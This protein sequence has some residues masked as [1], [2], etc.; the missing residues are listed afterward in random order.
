MSAAPELVAGPSTAARRRVTYLNIKAVESGEERIIEGWATTGREDRVGDV[1]VPQGAKYE[2]P[3]PLLFAHQ[4]DKPIGSVIAATVSKAG[5]RIR[6]K[7]TA[8]VAQADEVWR[9]IQD[10]ALTAVSIG[11]QALKMTPLPTGGMRFDSWS[12]YELS[13]V[14]VPCNPDAKIAIGKGIAYAT[15]APIAVSPQFRLPTRPAPT[16]ALDERQNGYRDFDWAQSR[17]PIELRALTD[18]HRFGSGANGIQFD[19]P[20]GRPLAFVDNFGVFKALGQYAVPEIP[21]LPEQRAAAGMTRGQQ[22]VMINYVKRLN[23]EIGELAEA[24]TILARR[25]KALEAGAAESGLRL[26]GFW[27]EGMQAKPGDVFSHDG[28]SFAARM[29]TEETPSATSGDWQLIARRGANAR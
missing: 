23:G 17:L 2:L 22:E 21:R 9:L 24:V 10:G 27:R 18:V 11:F 12:W 1:V 14:A 16:K 7:L 13:V 6:A 26:R 8:G 4:H 3:L 15:A 25:V 29:P 19:D 5:I 28:S 20:F